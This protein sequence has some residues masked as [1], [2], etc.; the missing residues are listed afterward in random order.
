MH[1]HANR[2]RL[3][4]PI[5]A[6]LAAGVVSIPHHEASAPRLAEVSAV[7]LQAAATALVSGLD[8]TSLA[9]LAAVAPAPA[10]SA[11]ASSWTYNPNYTVFDNLLANLPLEIRNVL[12]PPLYVVASV[13]GAI[14]GLAYLVVSPI[15]KLLKIDPFKPA[16]AVPAAATRPAG[17]QP[18]P[19]ESPAAVGNPVERTAA[20]APKA[21]SKPADSTPAGEPDPQI[22]VDDAAGTAVRGRTPAPLTAVADDAP[23]APA[24]ATVVADTVADAP[25]SRP[26]PTRARAGEGRSGDA[27]SPAPKRSAR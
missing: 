20:A 23:A 22:G 12:L 13:V 8:D 1:S 26:A 4:Y 7:N 14:V 16:A 11:A 21:P 2:H 9:H 15:L 24:A 17:P 25:A 27:S 19:A 5:A 10:A 18:V 3:V 6:M